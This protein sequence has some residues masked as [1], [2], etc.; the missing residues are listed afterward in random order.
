M[1]I[2]LVHDDFV[3]SGGAESLFA[4]IAEIFPEAP[5]Y[6]SIVDWQKLPQSIDRSRIKTSFIQKL[7]IAKKWYKI[8]LPLY[9][10]AFESFDFSAYDLVISS[11]TRF[12]KCIITKP[13]TEHICYINSV[14]RFLWHEASKTHYYKPYLSFFIS[15]LVSWLKRVDRASAARVVMFVANSQ[16]VKD[17]IKKN[18]KRDAQVIY[19]FADLNFFKPAKIRNWQLKSQ[20]Y[21]LVVSRLVKW[22][23]ISLAVSACQNAGFNLKIVGTGP[24]KKRLHSLTINHQPSTINHTE[25]LGKVSKE[26][27]LELYQNSLGLIVPQEEDFGIASLEAQACGIPVIAYNKGGQAEIIV[28]GKTGLFFG[29]QKVQDIEDAIIRASNVKWS[30]SACFSNAQKFS[31]ENFVRGIK[32]LVDGKSSQRP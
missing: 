11:T 20:K 13:K 32:N 21:F 28:E 1:K 24:D 8:F 16:N 29:N 5:I 9:P 26:K 15:P 30:V 18:Y 3:Q 19:P 25:F 4:A 10:L 2:A 27:L 23:M 6:T 7:A 12:S 14:P 22:K 17:S 31:K